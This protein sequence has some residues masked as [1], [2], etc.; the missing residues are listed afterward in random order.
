MLKS[1]KYSYQNGITLNRFLLINHNDYNGCAALPQN[2]IKPHNITIYSFP[3]VPIKSYISLSEFYSR[4]VYYNKLKGLVPHY[5]IDQ[6]S[7]WQLLEENQESSF[8]NSKDN[9]VIVICGSNQKAILRT[10]DLVCRILQT[11]NL[12]LNNI[13]IINNSVP[14]FFDLLEDKINKLGLPVFYNEDEVIEENIDKAAHCDFQVYFNSE[15][16]Q[17]IVGKAIRAIRI[18]VS[19]GELSY[20][21]HLINGNWLP[22]VNDGEMSGSAASYIDGFQIKYISDKYKIL[23]RFS[24]INS[25]PI[26]WRTTNIPIPTKKYLDSFEFKIE[27][28]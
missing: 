23:Y 16:Q 22:W 3:D 21:T 28:K 13:K 14:M 27:E 1:D 19:E 4:Q 17:P 12:G 26:S 6:I 20:R 2:Q 9:I 8:S 25:K 18:K 7:A 15:W 11:Y 10:V 24:I 5:F